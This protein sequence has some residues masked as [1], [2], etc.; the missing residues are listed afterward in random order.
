MR[1]V[2]EHDEPAGLRFRRQCSSGADQGL[3]LRS[4][5]FDLREPPCDGAEVDGLPCFGPLGSKCL[6]SVLAG[7][8]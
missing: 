8:A 2:H 5:R 1:V 7:R 4:M 3:C 6:D